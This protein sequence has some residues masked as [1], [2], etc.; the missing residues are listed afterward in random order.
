M[1]F[2]FSH[3][4]IALNCL[5]VLEAPQNGV[6]SCDTQTVGG[7]C[8]FICDEGFTL[9]GSPKRNCTP[10]LQ[11]NGQPT[12]CDPPMC[13][14]LRPPTKGFVVFPCTRE[15][16]H[17]CDIICAHGYNITSSKPQTCEVNATNDLIWSEGPN[18]VGEYSVTLTNHFVFS[19]FCIRESVDALCKDAA[20]A[21]IM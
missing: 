10:S 1:L 12:V 16:G 21:C 14:K 15:E 9:R 5:P 19:P 2:Y 20:D 3:T 11:W 18:C 13:P 17:S 4:N 7:T 8:N 6:I